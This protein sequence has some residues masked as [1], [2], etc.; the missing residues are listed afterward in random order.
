MRALIALVLVPLTGWAAAAA[1]SP[2]WRWR[3]PVLVADAPR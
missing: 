3:S 2:A 1:E